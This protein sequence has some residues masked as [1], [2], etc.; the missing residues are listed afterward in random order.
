MQA[1][2]GTPRDANH[3]N[4]LVSP[5][6]VSRASAETLMAVRSAYPL[7]SSIETSLCSSAIIG[8]RMNSH[9]GALPKIHLSLPY[10]AS[11]VSIPTTTFLTLL[12]LASL[13]ISSVITGSA[14]TILAK[15]LLST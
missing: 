6:Q 11:R 4:S 9:M 3:Q 14:Q 7:S 2:V 15:I 8:L 10:M 5:K 13:I 12:R 1:T